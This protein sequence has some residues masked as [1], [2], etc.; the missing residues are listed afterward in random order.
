[1]WAVVVPSYLLIFINHRVLN[2]AANAVANAG[3]RW[4]YLVAA[5]GGGLLV[6]EGFTIA[7]LTLTWLVYR[8][9]DIQ[10]HHTAAEPPPRIDVTTSALMR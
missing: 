8:E 1:M 4:P 2:P 5:W 7:A 9:S 6:A 10:N 3:G